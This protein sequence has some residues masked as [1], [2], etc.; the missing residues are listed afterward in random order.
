M[1]Y[2]G[3]VS[4]PFSTLPQTGY[5]RNRVA[6]GIL[7][8]GP[9]AFHR[10]HQ[11]DY[12]DRLLADDPRWGIAAVSLRSPE[13]VDALARQDGLYTLAI[14]DSETSFR[15]IGA[16]NAFY[17]PGSSGEVRA[18]LADPAVRIVSSTVTEKG[19]C[20]GGD[21]SLDFDHPDIVRDLALP[22]DP[23]SIVGWLAL[24]LA[25]RR[26]AGLAPFTPI[27]C[28][29]MVANGKKLGAAVAAFARRLDPEL[30]GWIEGEVRFPDTMV[31]SIT[32]ASDERLRALVRE[33][34][35]FA[36]EIPVSREAYAAWVIEDV[37]PEDG[38]D[39]ASVGIVLAGDVGAWEK[40]KLRILNGA[41]STLAY[42]GLLLGHTTVADAMGDADLA[43]FIERLVR[44]D[45]IASLMPSPI[46]LQAYA[47]EI[48]ERFR[49]PAIGHRLA[50]IAWDGSQKL[51]YRI[52]D[53]IGEALAA[54]RSV[55]RLA[56]PI[57]AWMLFIERQAG[58]GEKIVDPLA[59]ALK[60]I[61]SRPGLVERLL[62]LRQVFRPEIAGDERFRSAV[63]SAVVKMRE[64]LRGVLAARP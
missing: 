22:G 5:D 61:A 44:E 16:H 25:D 58:A 17:G 42:V 4:A 24:G 51:P 45:V 50:Q 27:C 43:A 29:N 21:G 55:E 49:N 32:P 36:D 6:T 11:A 15:T 62:D 39:F 47:G 48:F 52:L 34:T 19:Y 14:L 12:V 56:V 63:E 59:A 57:A 38:P 35:G 26:A 54:G 41:H 8:F 7:H 28:D 3:F 13:T 20:L 30:A 46:D 40:A 18:R 33:R 23:V 37:L 31:D 2:G 53:T 1:R 60:E 10:A 64:N 9:G